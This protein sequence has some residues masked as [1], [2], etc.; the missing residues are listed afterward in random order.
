MRA[1]PLLAALLAAACEGTTRPAD[2]GLDAAPLDVAAPDVAVDASEVSAPQPFERTVGGLTVRGFPLGLSLARG[3]VAVLRSPTA[4]PF[5]EVGVVE[6]GASTTRFYDP[7]VDTPADVTWRALDRLT[8]APETTAEGLRLRL[9][10]EGGLSADVHVAQAERGVT[11]RVEVPGPEVA[12]LRFNFASDDGAYHGLGEQFA[13]ADARGRVVPMQLQTGGTTSGTNEQH[14]PIPFLVSSKGYGIFVETREAGAF[15]VASTSADLVRATFEGAR[16]TVHLYEN[17]DPLR[18][19]ADYTRDTGLPRLPPRWAFAPQQWRNV[20]RSGDEM[21]EDARRLRSEGIPTTT[22]WIDNPWQVSY[23]DGRIDE[24]RFP[25]PAQL[26]QTLAS[27]GYRVIFWST[28][29]LDAVPEG[30]QP[31]NEAERLFVTARERGYLVRA[32]NNTPYISP[33]RFFSPSG[34]SDAFGALVDF[35]APGASRYFEETLR[36]TLELGGRGYK[37]DYAED[38]LPELAGRR[39]GLRFANGESERTQRWFYPQG[40]HGAY[41]AALDRWANGDGF[42]L[43]RASSWGGQRVCDIIWPGD[44]DNDFRPGTDGQVGGLPAAV[45]ALISLSESGF[46]SFAS[47]TGGYRGGRPT[48]EA[49][50]RWAEHTAMSPFMQLGGGGE[51]HNPWTYDAEASTIYRDLARLHNQLVP[52]FYAQ[53]RRASVDGTPPVRSLP[54]AFPNDPGARNDPFTYLI[55]DDLLAAPVVTA[56]AIRRVVHFPPGEWVSWYTGFKFAGPADL[57]VPAV[58]GQPPLFVRVGAAVEML[59]PEVQTLVPTTASDIIDADDRANTRV[60]RVVPGAETTVTLDDATARVRSTG[61]ERAEVVFTAGARV[62]RLRV[63]FDFGTMAGGAAVRVGTTLAVEDR[64]ATTGE[65]TSCW[66]TTVS[67]PLI[68][69][70]VEGSTTVSVTRDGS[71]P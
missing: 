21:L 54:L 7:R 48:R 66:S 17:P 16:A 42:T 33:T 14:V 3:G 15:D 12:L 55:G 49:L 57:G 22:M 6:G 20:W 47:D 37:L 4:R 65:C 10:G 25:N 13:G 58:I 40:Y 63:E 71:M 1:R 64:R 56:G 67:R 31:M 9:A 69:V 45:S 50:L 11:L 36:H 61:A 8:A 28:P 60:L 62:T 5:L 30:A 34:M 70:S 38:V 35:S 44:L 43:V 46:P 26:M 68:T 2:G 41:R 27:L 23:N 52:Y 39:T 53:V 29:F 51:S 24:A 18:V 19:V 59:A 32:S